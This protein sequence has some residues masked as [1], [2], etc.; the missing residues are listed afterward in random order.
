MATAGE[1]KERGNEELAAGNLELA[2]EFYE[3][4]LA[5]DPNSVQLWGNRALARERQGNAQGA[6]EDA[7]K[8]VKLDAGYVKGWYRLGSAREAT[9]H[10]AEA[11]T[12]YA[13]GLHPAKEAGGR[14][15]EQMEGS[16]ERAR[17]KLA[18]RV[19]SWEEAQ[20]K[21]DMFLGEGKPSEAME[22]YTVALNMLGSSGQPSQV[23]KALAARAECSRQ[24]GHER[25]AE[26]DCTAA[27]GADPGNWR[28]LVR[29]ALAREHGEDFAGALEDLKQ[30]HEIEATSLVS[31][32]LRRLEHAASL[33]SVNMAGE[34]ERD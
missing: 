8:A 32:S 29:R 26:R 28:A 34:T 17:G 2:E 22:W 12:A 24:L 16:L 19:G 15:L 21:G 25:G 20:A 33:H 27:L 10:V 31:E 9:G 1:L 13:E 14:H 3:H 18:G 4:A 11:V 6:L 5:A 30:A 7:E 23:G